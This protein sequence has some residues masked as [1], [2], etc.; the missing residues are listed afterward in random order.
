MKRYDNALRE[1]VVSECR[2]VGSVADE[3]AEHE[4]LHQRFPLDPGG[5]VL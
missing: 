3:D 2:Q 4:C 5:R 1:Q